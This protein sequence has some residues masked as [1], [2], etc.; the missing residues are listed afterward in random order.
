MTDLFGRSP[1][2]KI[3]RLCGLDT[4]LERFYRAAGTRDG[5]RSECKECNL[6]Q[7]AARYRKNPKPYIERVRKW[8]RENPERLK[9]RADAFRESGK[10]RISDRKSHLKRKYG[11]TLE[12][13]DEMH[14]AQDGVCAICRQPRPEDR[15]LHVDHD[16]DTGEIRGLLC[17]KC[18]NALGDFND[19]HDLFQRAA[20][21]LDCDPELAEIARTRARALA[22]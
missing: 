19:D 8:Q 21:Y 10:K 3:C 9:A 7:R 22:L 5:L 16:H 15:S 18:N 11:L 17:F 13:Y 12:Q 2:S 1:N 6:A 4:P 20:D 14:A